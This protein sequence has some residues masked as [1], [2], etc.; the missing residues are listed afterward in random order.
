VQQ[1]WKGL[2]R[3]STV[4]L[5]FALSVIVGL[6]LGKWLDEKF[7]TGGLLTIVWFFFGLVAG[8]RAIYRAAKRAERDLRDEDAA[9]RESK[10]KYLDDDHPR[11]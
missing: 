6:M 7:D 9:A 5:E 1:D 11:P 3:Y 4:G 10:R 2:G 8:G